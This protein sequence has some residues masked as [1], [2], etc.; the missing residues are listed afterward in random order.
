VHQRRIA[1]RRRL[2][3]VGDETIDRRLFP[4]VHGGRHGPAEQMPEVFDAAV[5]DVEQRLEEQVQ[6]QVV[7]ADV[8]DE[9]DRRPHFADVGKILIG[10][11]ADV[12]AAANTAPLQLGHD[13]Q[14]R[15]LVRDQ[16]VGV[17]V[18]GALRQG[19]NRRGEG[20][21]LLRSNRGAA[22]LNQ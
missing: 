18:A 2:L 5:R 8:D 15:A 10:T 17:E 6:Q 9:G 3:E 14:V 11:D 22:R 19:G 16:I 13:L 12:G 1:I 20:G 21:G 7:A 4:A